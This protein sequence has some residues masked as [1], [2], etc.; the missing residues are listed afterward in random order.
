[1]D[2]TWI[3]SVVVGGIAVVG[4]FASR[5]AK[6]A[7]YAAADESLFRSQGTFVIDAT[8]GGGL[9]GLGVNDSAVGIGEV[10][11][12]PFLYYGHDGG[13]ATGSN[14][15]TATATTTFMVSPAFDYFVIDGVSIGGEVTFGTFDVSQTTTTGQSSTTTDVLSGTF[16]GIAPRVGFDFA[17][18]Q[19]FSIWV[20][21][22]FGYNHVSSSVPNQSG[23][24]SNSNFAI[25]MDAQL[26]WH[27]HPRF[28][29][30]IGPGISRDL[31][32]SQSNDNG[33]GTTVSTDEA[34]QTR[35]RLL[36][37]TMGGVL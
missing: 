27:P 8:S 12:T 33:N 11:L 22:G 25:G 13:D 15:S 6:A 21:A 35:W 14:P 37:F 3:R 17:F 16:V 7:R 4:L 2:R 30:G 26:L 9:G 34:K 1:M 31:S 32:A 28:F 36:T 20:R 24:S 19:S 18:N 23:S 5:D 10:G 29:V